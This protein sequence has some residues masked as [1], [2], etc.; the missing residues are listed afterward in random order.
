MNDEVKEILIELIDYYNVIGTEDDPG[1]VPFA[2]IVQR[3][4]KALKREAAERNRLDRLRSADVDPYAIDVAGTR[5]RYIKNEN[6]W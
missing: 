1:F 3:A 2:N 4:S 6:E 5:E